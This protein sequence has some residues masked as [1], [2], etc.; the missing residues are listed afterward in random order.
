MAEGWTRHL[1]GAAIEAF[2]AGLIAH[3]LNP[4]AVQVMGEAGVDISAHRSKTLGELA[5]KSFDLVVTVCSGADAA[6]PAFACAKRRIH[7]PFDDPPALAQTAKTRDEALEI[8]RRVRDEIRAF[9]LDLP[10]RI[11][12]G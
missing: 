4:M 5:D 10:R 9:V 11:E 7:Q 8:Y 6:C 12:A 2:S 3:G 1:H